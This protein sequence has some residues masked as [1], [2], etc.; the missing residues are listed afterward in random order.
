MCN[1]MHWRYLVVAPF[2]IVVAIQ[3]LP[4]SRRIGR[5]KGVCLASYEERDKLFASRR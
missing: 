1:Y 2:M 3:H 5:L 4:Q